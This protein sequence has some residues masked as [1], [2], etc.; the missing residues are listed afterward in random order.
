MGCESWNIRN[1]YKSIFNE[2]R[3][4]LKQ[5]CSKCQQVKEKPFPKIRLNINIFKSFEMKS[6]L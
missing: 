5:L 6:I 3:V 4:K 2:M 1:L